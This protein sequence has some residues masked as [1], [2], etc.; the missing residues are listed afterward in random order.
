MRH[1]EPALRGGSGGGLSRAGVRCPRRLPRV[2]TDEQQGTR[3]KRERHR[4]EAL[5]RRKRKW[6]SGASVLCVSSP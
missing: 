2:S 6:P 3:Q 5:E 4:L 1:G